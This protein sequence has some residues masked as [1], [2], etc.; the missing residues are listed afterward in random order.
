M[1]EKFD[2]DVHYDWEPL[3]VGAH[4]TPHEYG[5]LTI[6]RNAYTSKVLLYNEGLLTKRHPAIRG[7]L[8]A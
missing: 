7:L 6:L 3:D 1:E 4:G 5:L 8:L 2:I